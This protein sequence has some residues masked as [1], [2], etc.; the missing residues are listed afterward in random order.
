MWSSTAFMGT[1]PGGQTLSWSSSLRSSGAFR[2]RRRPGDQRVSRGIRVDLARGDSIDDGGPF[3][4]VNYVPCEM[5]QKSP[6]DDLTQSL[7]G[8]RPA[9]VP[10]GRRPFG[11]A[12]LRTRPKPPDGFDE[13][14]NSLAARRDGLH[15]RR[16]PFIGLMG[17]EREGHLGGGDQAVA[18]LA[19]GF[20]HP[21]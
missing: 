17:M 16:S 2:A 20:V 9:T 3:V 1:A 18:S 21:Q 13:L 8:A 11:I 15:D 6:Y 4:R 19:V 7:F 5:I 14:L 12:A 10:D